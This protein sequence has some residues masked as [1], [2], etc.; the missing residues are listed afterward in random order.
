[1]VCLRV[2][3]QPSGG[4]GQ[5]A[6]VCVTRL[7]HNRRKGDDSHCQRGDKKFECGV[8]VVC[9]HECKEIKTHSA[10]CES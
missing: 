1:M 3:F 9:V 8:D 4:A 6:S 7:H 10:E 5:T 2:R